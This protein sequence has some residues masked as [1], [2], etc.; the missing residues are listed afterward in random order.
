MALTELVEKL[1]TEIGKVRF[2]RSHVTKTM[3]FETIRG[4]DV[5]F[6]TCLGADAYC[7]STVDFPIVIMD[8]ATQCNLLQS[9]IP[10]M[11]GCRY[12]VLVGDHKQ[13]APLSCRTV[14]EAKLDVSLYEHLHMVRGKSAM[15]KFSSNI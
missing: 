15:S 3:E 6:S 11:K 8:E 2:K 14:K 9:L 1:K 4:S 5:T 7:M 13:L 12:A 10:L